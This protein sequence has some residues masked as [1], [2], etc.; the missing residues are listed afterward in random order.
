MHEAP[1]A[2]CGEEEWWVLFVGPW[3]CYRTVLGVA[4]QVGIILYMYTT[5]KLIKSERAFWELTGVNI[6]CTFL[7]LTPT[8]TA[9]QTDLQTKVQVSSPPLG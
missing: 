6:F 3:M 9:L 1:D 2:E 5:L 8:N 7:K 4:L